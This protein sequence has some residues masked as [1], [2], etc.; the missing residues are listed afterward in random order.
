M[1]GTKD[2][3]L[4]RWKYI[5][6]DLLGCGPTKWKKKKEYDEEQEKEWSNICK[7]Q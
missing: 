4:P 6:L 5:Y 7:D 3:C 1:R 2:F